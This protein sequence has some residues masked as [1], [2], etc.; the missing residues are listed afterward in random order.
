MGFRT[1]T[2][3]EQIRERDE[4]IDTLRAEVG[5]AKAEEAKARSE[6]EERERERVERDRERER[7][8]G[9]RKEGSAKGVC[10]CLSL[11]VRFGIEALMR[12]VSASD[13]YLLNKGSAV[14]Y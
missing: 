12:A 3:E 7:K 11:G 6:L 1:G 4:L 5:L 10:C 2:V 9:K 8:E 14:R 13:G